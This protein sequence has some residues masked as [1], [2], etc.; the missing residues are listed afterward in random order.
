M[1]G[2]DETSYER[3]SRG[4]TA[5]ARARWRPTSACVRRPSPGPDIPRLRVTLNTAEC[6][7]GW[8]VET[9]KGAPTNSNNAYHCLC[10]PFPGLHL[11]LS[12]L[13]LEGLSSR[14]RYIFPPSVR[15]KVEGRPQ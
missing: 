2:N 11:K 14:H 1:R 7:E 6:G 9:R 10:V 12:L 3:C 5:R 15:S 13:K 4:A 8:K